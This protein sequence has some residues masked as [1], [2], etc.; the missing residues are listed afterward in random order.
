MSGST[1]TD[2]RPG[3]TGRPP[4][5]ERRKA[6]TRLEIARAA[7]DLFTTHGVA[8]TSAEQIAQAAGIS[9]RTLWR[10]FP[11][12]EACVRPLLTAG[13]EATA[14]VLRAWS[15]DR[16]LTEVLDALEETEDDAPPLRVA[17]D[18]ATVLA[19]VRLTRSEPGL[20]AVRLQA[21]ADAEPVFAQ[22]LA[23]R[24]GLPAEDLNSMIQAA[25]ITS[26]LRVTIEQHAWNTTDAA[27]DAALFTPLRIALLAVA[28][29]LPD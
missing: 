10:Y 29:G 28:Q 4:L 16:P 19:L 8:A 26:A 13:I 9:T 15:P 27:D 17:E 24:A 25:M 22:A 1:T 20:Q 2:G 18:A 5:S 12:K 6:A 21:L 23:Q 7:I 11:S 3:R 14:R